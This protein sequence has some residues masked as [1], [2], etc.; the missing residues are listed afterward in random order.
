MQELK[1]HPEPHM[2][3]VVAENRKV[4]EGVFGPTEVTTDYRKGQILQLVRPGV[5]TPWSWM[6]REHENEFNF[7]IST[8]L[9]RKATDS[10]VASYHALKKLID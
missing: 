2:I 8:C 4:V 3:V 9:L 10:E 6:V 7:S 1:F 5:N